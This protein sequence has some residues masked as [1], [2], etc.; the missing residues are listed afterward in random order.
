M[1]ENSKKE[2]IYIKNV[3]ECMGKAGVTFY[4]N[5]G[6]RLTYDSL[7]KH[8]DYKDFK[9]II[10]GY[11]VELFTLA[12]DNSITV[13]ASLYNEITN[14]ATGKEFAKT[15]LKI[16]ATTTTYQVP[17]Y[18]KVL[19]KEIMKQIDSGKITNRNL[20][21]GKEESKLDFNRWYDLYFTGVLESDRKKAQLHYIYTVMTEQMENVFYTINYT[22]KSVPYTEGPDTVNLGV[23]VQTLI[24]P[25]SDELIYHEYAGTRVPVPEYN[26]NFEGGLDFLKKNWFFSVNERYPQELSLTRAWSK[27]VRSSGSNGK[28]LGVACMFQEATIHKNEENVLSDSRQFN[29]VNVFK[30]PFGTDY[31]ISNLQESSLGANAI[32]SPGSYY[33]TPASSSLDPFQFGE[34]DWEVDE[35]KDYQLFNAYVFSFVKLGWIDPEHKDEYILESGEHVDDD[36]G[37]S[38][39]ATVNPDNSD[40]FL[41]SIQKG[42]NWSEIAQNIENADLPA[43]VVNPSTG[44]VIG[45]P[46]MTIPEAEEN[47]QTNFPSMTTDPSALGLNVYTGRFS[48]IKAI[49]QEM[50]H[51]DFVDKIAKLLTSPLEAVVGV[52]TVPVSPQIGESQKVQIGNY[53]SNTSMYVV[54]SQFNTINLAMFDIVPLY[55]GSDCAYL[56]YEETRIFLYIPYCGMTELPVS[57]VMGTAVSVSLTVDVMTGLCSANVYSDGNFIATV[58]GDCAYK[59]PL[60]GVNYSGNYGGGLGGIIT[61]AKEYALGSGTTIVGNISGSP[62]GYVNNRCYLI[63][64]R[65][66]PYYE[67]GGGVNRTFAT[68][69][70]GTLSQFTGYVV[71]SKVYQPSGDFGL[72]TKEELSE[73][74]SL[75]RQGVYV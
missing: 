60:S 14:F 65:P 47:L 3:L 48:N 51:G 68:L 13:P 52:L 21:G 36:G 8:I 70:R 71:C 22:K 35:F 44:E 11:I 41:D 37:L 15:V 45:K 69:R 46:G 40:A 58:D 25:A 10:T 2:K 17:S 29:A 6:E 18:V 59:Y 12:K 53:T 26:P 54:K 62:A 64:H 39:S 61:A 50:W 24:Y 66:I 72:A 31:W 74:D 32:T 9:K 49:V 4:S 28:S 67:D 20:I 73:I 34:A 56:D 33:T 38:G 30:V 5:A 63:I 57:S 55:E 23:R 7:V 19:F 16:F 27:K 75:L 1:V 43:F 42:E